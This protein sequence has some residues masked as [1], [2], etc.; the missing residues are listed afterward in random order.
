MA[1]G[2]ITVLAFFPVPDAQENKAADTYWDRIK[3][4]LMTADEYF[5][6][7]EDKSVWQKRHEENA[8]SEF[9]GVPVQV[10]IGAA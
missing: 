1:D 2:K 9:F 6:N 7:V 8:L 3:P 4:T 5:G 10:S